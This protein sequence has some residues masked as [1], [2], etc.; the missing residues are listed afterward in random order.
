MMMI[1]MIFIIPLL[2]KNYENKTIG[3][4]HCYLSLMYCN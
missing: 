1:V 2:Y 3:K 4:E